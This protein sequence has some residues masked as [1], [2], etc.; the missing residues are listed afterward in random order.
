V[1]RQLWMPK[2]AYM[3]PI[4]WQSCRLMVKAERSVNSFGVCLSNM[5]LSSILIRGGEPPLIPRIFGSQFRI[6]LPGRLEILQTCC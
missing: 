4:G 5:T 1:G 6:L 3:A 2:A